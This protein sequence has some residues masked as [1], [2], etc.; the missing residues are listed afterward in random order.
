[1]LQSSS[2]LSGNKNT[3]Y[4]FSVLG[5]LL[6]LIACINY[7]NLTTAKASLR[8][9]EVS[10][11]KIVGAGRMQLFYQFLSEAFLV[12]IMALVITLVLVNLCLPAFNTITDKHFTLS[13]LSSSLWKIAGI[14]LLSAFVLSS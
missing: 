14:T 2:F 12:S 11:R 10:V 1:D 8:A 9:K 4:I 3:V 7:I 5:I 6:L 13:L